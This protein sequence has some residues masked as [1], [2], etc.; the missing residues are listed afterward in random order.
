MVIQPV[1]TKNPGRRTVLSI[2]WKEPGLL[3][4]EHHGILQVGWTEPCIRGGLKEDPALPR[5]R[6]G[7]RHRRS[8]WNFARRGQVALGVKAYGR[9]RGARPQRFMPQL[10]EEARQESLRA[11]IQFT[12]QLAKHH[13]EA[14][15]QGS[16]RV[17]SPPLAPVLE[18]ARGLPVETI[19]GFQLPGCLPLRNVRCFPVA[20]HLPSTVSRSALL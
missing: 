13:R 11:V 3:A 8:R 2:D 20:H 5:V 1:G 7:G 9:C 17:I 16:H 14:L 19:K 4:L 15:Q 12:P 6:P 10:G 18:P